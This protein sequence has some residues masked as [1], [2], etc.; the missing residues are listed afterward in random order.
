[1]LLEMNR[2]QQAVLRVRFD[3]TG[4]SPSRPTVR[5]IVVYAS[6]FCRRRLNTSGV[7]HAERAPPQVGILQGE[8]STGGIGRRA[9][10]VHVLSS[11]RTD[12]LR[13]SDE[14]AQS[15]VAPRNIAGRC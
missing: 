10:A 15:Q 11:S 14:E 8:P 12:E 13:P 4:W 9:L 6:A 3:M 2:P 5:T 1:M 7:R